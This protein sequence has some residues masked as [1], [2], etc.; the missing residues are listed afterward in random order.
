MAFTRKEFLSLS[1]LGAAGT[2]AACTPQARTSDD[3][4][5]PASN[6]DLEE[7][8]SLKL[9]MTQWSYDEDNDCY[10]QLGIQYCTKPASKSVNTLSV[11][12]PGKYLSGKKNGST[13]ECEVSEK[14]VVGSFTASTAPIVM[15]I[16]TATLAP[17]SAPTSYSY[18]GLA[19][20]LEA[21][22]V[23]V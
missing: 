21:G 1:A 3:T 19:P 15:P 11:F 23:Y 8:K 7:F 13:Y 17:Q 4:N 10:Y 18:E 2:L 12:V 5:Q 6:V 20:Y 22:C 9:D 14:A 16:N